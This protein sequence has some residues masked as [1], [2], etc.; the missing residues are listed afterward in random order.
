VA[1]ALFRAGTVLDRPEWRAAA[2]EA[3]RAALRRDEARW[4]V[5]GATVCH[6]Y[7][8]LLRV[9]ARVARAVPGDTV[10]RD[11][12]ARLTGRVLEHADERAPFGFRH[13]MRFPAAARS[14]Y[15]H[16]AV[17]TAGMLEGA[18]G[19]ALALLPVDDTA[20]LPWDRTLGL[21]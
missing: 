1:A 3:L 10:L 4:A 11:G 6:G 8:G 16:R 14:P 21:A 9:V 20:A 17:D 15:P 19:V 7:A 12:V 18:A 2:V 13:L 5:D